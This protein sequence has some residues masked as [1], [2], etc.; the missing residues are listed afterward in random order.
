MSDCRARRP[1]CVFT[2]FAPAASRSSSGLRLRCAHTVSGKPLVTRFFAMPWPM[3]PRPMKPMRGFVS[4][5]MFP[6]N[7]DRWTV[8]HAGPFPRV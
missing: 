7:R 3:S 8:R 6:P 4:A 2:S 5:F 1:R